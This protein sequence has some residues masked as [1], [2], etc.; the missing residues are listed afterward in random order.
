MSWW[1]ETFI[2]YNDS[3]S[4]TGVLSK[5]GDRRDAQENAMYHLERA[6][7][8]LGGH[9]ESFRK[10]RGGRNA[11]REFASVYVDKRE[12]LRAYIYERSDSR[13]RRR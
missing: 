11:G 5:G 4:F 1:A 12:V 10:A 2:V 7:K 3:E 9:I 8:D 13:K 6:A